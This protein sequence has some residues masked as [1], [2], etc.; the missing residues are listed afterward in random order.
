MIPTTTTE[1]AD[2]IA[3]VR[4]ATGALRTI[5]L[6][7]CSDPLA[8]GA[9][10][11]AALAGTDG[12]DDNDHALGLITGLITDLTETLADILDDNAPALDDLSTAC[13]HLRQ[14]IPRLRSAHRELG[15]EALC[16]RATR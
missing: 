11:L 6:G 14:Q 10:V 3:A 4:L 16:A 1:T 15:G 9:A 7:D 2:A 13:A 12:A 8:D 5:A